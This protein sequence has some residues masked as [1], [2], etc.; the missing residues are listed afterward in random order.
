M[1]EQGAAEPQ[2]AEA[3]AAESLLEQAISVTKQT[4]RS[5]AEELFEAL[6]EQAMQGTVTWSKNLTVTFNDAIAAIDRM[7]SKQLGAVMHADEFQ[8]LE[9]SWRGLHH[10]V[11][12]SETGSG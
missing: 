1:Q 3:Q 8:K 7:V 5:R 11:M 2:A 9:G 12:N 4:E 10:L 6:A